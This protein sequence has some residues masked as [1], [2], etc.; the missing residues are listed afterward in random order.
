MRSL[1]LLLFAAVAGCAPRPLETIAAD[2]GAPV[3]PTARR[4]DRATENQAV[5]VRSVRIVQPAPVP[6]TRPHRVEGRG[7]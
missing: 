7:N 3:I 4:D 2:A 6:S 5:F 1:V